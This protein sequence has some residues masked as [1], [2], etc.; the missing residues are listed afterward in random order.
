ME[1]PLAC[2]Q[3]PRQARPAKLSAFSYA[4]ASTFPN[5]SRAHLNWMMTTFLKVVS[6]AETWLIK[7]LR[8]KFFYLAGL[9]V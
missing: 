7:Q 5:E 4:S 3:L 8:F 1:M 9:P 6:T 2:I